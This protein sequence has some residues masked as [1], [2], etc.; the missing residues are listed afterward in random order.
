LELS[1]DAQQ[2][3]LV[4]VVFPNIAVPP[5]AT[6]TNAYVRFIVDEVRPPHTE[7]PLTVNV[8]GERTAH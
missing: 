2:L 8:Y 7:R 6:V 1:F 4:G 3:Q 5:N